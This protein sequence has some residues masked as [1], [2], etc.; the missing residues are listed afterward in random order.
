M[1]LGDSEPDIQGL[2]EKIVVMC[3][4]SELRLRSIAS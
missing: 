4:E 2:T 1:S 3:G